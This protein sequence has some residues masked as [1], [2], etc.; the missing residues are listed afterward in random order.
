[1]TTAQQVLQVAANEIGY[2]EQ[3]LGSDHTKYGVWFGID[4]APWAAMFVSYCFYMA[5]LPFPIT[6]P[7]GFAF[8]PYAAKW[9]KEHGWWDTAPQ[10]GD[11]VFFDWQADGSAD[12]VGIVEKVNPDNSIVAIRGNVEN[13]VCRR[14]SSTGMMGYGRPPY[15]STTN[16]EPH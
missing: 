11:V 1:M 16:N 8:H 6:T 15:T 7:K 4:P 2:K 12:H 3:P 13:Q 10:V 14:S 5:G 9:F